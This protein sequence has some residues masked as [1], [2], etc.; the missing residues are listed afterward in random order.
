MDR[1]VSTEEGRKLAQSWN[2]QFVEVSAKQLL[3]SFPYLCNIHL[4][5]CLRAC[6]STYVSVYLFLVRFS[7][8]I[9]R[10]LK[11]IMNDFQF[12]DLL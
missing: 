2:A 8:F 6:V 5:M 4:C 1:K 11:F 3:V 10:I 9:K 12:L 7:T